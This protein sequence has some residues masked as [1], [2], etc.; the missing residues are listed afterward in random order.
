MSDVNL[1][2]HDELYD[3]KKQLETFKYCCPIFITGTFG[4]TLAKEDD[5]IGANG[6]TPAIRSG[7][8]TFVFFNGEIYGIT[9]G[10]VVKALELSNE[11]NHQKWKVLIGPNAAYP[12]QAQMH[13]FVPEGNRQIHIN[14]HFHRAP[15]DEFT[16]SCPDVAFARIAN[17]T[18]GATGRRALPLKA[19]P[20]NEV[21]NIKHT[22]GIATGYPEK[23]RRSFEI[24]PSLNRLALSTAVAIAPFECISETKI[25]LV[26]ELPSDPEVD[27]LSGMS[28]GPIIWS[29]ESGWGF[30]GIIKDGR[31]VKPKEPNGS[32]HIINGHAIW[33]EGERLKYD[34]L[35]RWLES[36]PRDEEHIPDLSKRLVGPGIDNKL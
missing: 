24:N 22:C 18:F 31:D 26:S 21:F 2:V 13:F 15:G 36:I 10:H 5:L 11:K 23:S 32:N 34:Q 27:N 16:N 33:I 9:C 17:V 30:A 25:R 28:G 6:D 20:S 29:N 19:D 12:P 7:T 8:L 4:T 3:A 35:A 1:F 14:A